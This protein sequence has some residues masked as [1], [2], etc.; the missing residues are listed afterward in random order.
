MRH[1]F[2]VATVARTHTLLSH[3]RW[4]ARSSVGSRVARRLPG[5]HSLVA[6]RPLH[7]RPGLS[8]GR[9]GSGRP[10]PGVFRWSFARRHMLDTSLEQRVGRLSH[11]RTTVRHWQ[12]PIFTLEGYSGTPRQPTPRLSSGSSTRLVGR[13]TRAGST[14][15]PYSASQAPSDS[16]DGAVTALVCVTTGAGQTPGPFLVSRHPLFRGAA[17]CW[18]S[19]SLPVGGQLACRQ[20]TPGKPGCGLTL[21]MY[22]GPG[23]VRASVVLSRVLV[24]V[25]VTPAVHLRGPAPSA[26]S[27]THPVSESGKY[28]QNSPCPAGRGEQTPTPVK[29]RCSWTHWVMVVHQQRAPKRVQRTGW[30]PEKKD[31]SR[32]KGQAHRGREYQ[33]SR[34]SVTMLLLSFEFCPPHGSSTVCSPGTRRRTE[35]CVFKG[36]RDGQKKDV[37]GLQPFKT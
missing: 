19:A 7:C 22:R 15:A 31:G 17:R 33:S 32:R 20:I 11:D 6:A 3:A 16:P 1:T 25:G 35:H 4:V 30:R 14:P 9:R 28:L 36:V 8:V 23:P 29:L 18:P 34:G 27:P 5:R 37:S 21:R 2:F 26:A 13:E 12:S 24:E 10:P